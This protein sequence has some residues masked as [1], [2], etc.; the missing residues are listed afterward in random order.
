MEKQGKCWLIPAS[1]LIISFCGFVLPILAMV[2]CLGWNEG[3]MSVSGCVVDFPFARAYAD[4]YYGLLLFSAFMLLMPLGVYVA[5]V[6]GLIMLAK[7]VALV[8][9][10]RRN[11]QSKE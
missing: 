2:N 11:E 5:F 1:M 4:V 3:S 10:K 6:V 8:V 9:C 7:R